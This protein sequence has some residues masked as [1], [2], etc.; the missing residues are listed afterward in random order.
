MYKLCS[1]N[2]LLGHLP[3]WMGPVT[4]PYTATVTV[5]VVSLCTTYCD[6]VDNHYQLFFV[7]SGEKVLCFHGPLLYEAK[8]IYCV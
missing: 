5:S 2:V 7:F 4:L 1:V 8:V 3:V 6:C